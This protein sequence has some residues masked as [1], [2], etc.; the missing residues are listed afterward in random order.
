MPSLQCD[1]GPDRGKPRQYC[2][3]TGCHLGRAPNYIHST[4]HDRDSESGPWSSSN[5]EHPNNTS[6]NR[7]SLLVPSLFT[8]FT[9]NKRPSPTDE[10]RLKAVEVAL[11]TRARDQVPNPSGVPSNQKQTVAVSCLWILVRHLYVRNEEHSAGPTSGRRGIRSRL[12][13]QK[14]TG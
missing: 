9:C 3:R 11:L 13:S 7:I 10:R 4:G 8:G 6:L 2:I 14:Q 12:R 5:G 1:A